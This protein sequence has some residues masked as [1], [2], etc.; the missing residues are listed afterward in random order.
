MLNLATKATH[1]TEVAHPVAR[2]RRR[3]VVTAIIFVIVLTA[4]VLV[5]AQWNRWRAM[6]L[7]SYDTRTEAILGPCGPRCD[8]P[9]VPGAHLWVG[10]NGLDATGGT[11][12][13]RSAHIVDVPKQIKIL[14]IRASSR[15]ENNGTFYITHA[16]PAPTRFLHPLDEV[17]VQP[18]NK[19]RVYLLIEFT[20]TKPGRYIARGL[21]VDYQAGWKKASRTYDGFAFGV[22]TP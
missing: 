15:V 19:K 4:G 1:E 22:D 16:G 10:F 5:T 18:G 11:V 3:H 7:A 17:K 21:R 2:R 9:V 14:S 12:R 13:L 6:G 8:H 20:V